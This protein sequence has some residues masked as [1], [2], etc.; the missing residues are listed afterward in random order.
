[1]NLLKIDFKFLYVTSLGALFF[2]CFLK[3]SPSQARLPLG[4]A[5]TAEIL[6]QNQMRAQGETQY[7]SQGGGQLLNFRG[8]FSANIQNDSDIQGELSF[9]PE[10]YTMA[11]FWK[12]VPYPDTVS[13]P[14]AGARMGFFYGRSEG[15][16]IYGLQGA[17][18]ISKIISM[19]RLGQLIPFAAL[20]VALESRTDSTSLRV[21]VSAGTQYTHPSLDRFHFLMEYGQPL[22][23]SD[24]HFS[25]ALSY[26][27]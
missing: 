7:A 21:K 1:M 14:A 20:P 8:R 9:S 23:N 25:L 10:G 19:G 12:W 3:A 4:N 15:Q 13:Q 26:D 18:T 24:Y 17:P 27:L 16:T 5:D 22:L 6:G 2:I 11:G